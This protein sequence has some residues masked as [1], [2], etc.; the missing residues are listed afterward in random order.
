MHWH[1][2]VED[3]PS[4]VISVIIPTL[5]EEKSISRLLMGFNHKLD[6]AG[7][8][9]IVVDGGS[10]DQTVAIAS[11]FD[12]MLLESPAGRAMQ[13]NRGADISKGRILWFLHAD[14]Q[15]PLDWQNSL[16]KLDEPSHNV[17]GRFN[18]ELSG[19]SRLLRVIEHNMNVRSCLTG[20]CTGDQAI[21]MHRKAFFEAGKFPPQALME[22][23]ELSKRLKKFSPPHCSKACVI[24]SS[25]YWETHGIIRTVLKMWGIRLRYY[26]GASPD[27]LRRRYYS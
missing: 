2:T 20:I 5:N 13:M 18:V 1:N 6:N 19:H 7:F 14:S 4:I 9:V 25:R 26:F 12:V 27:S 21:Y 10:K 17:W 24:T 23:I 22:D 11:G 15:I 16:L 8:E 3:S